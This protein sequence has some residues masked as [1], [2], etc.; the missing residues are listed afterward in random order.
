MVARVS[1][2]MRSSFDRYDHY[3][4]YAEKRGLSPQHIQAQLVLMFG[5]ELSSMQKK[6]EE[7]EE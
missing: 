3:L 2:G 7:T 1:G 6:R 5:D 4:E